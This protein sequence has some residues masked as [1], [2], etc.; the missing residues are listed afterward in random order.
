MTK[1]KLRS[2]SPAQD[3]IHKLRANFTNEETGRSK[4]VKFGAEGYDDY[5]I[6][7]KRDGKKIANERKELYIERHGKDLKTEDP[8]RAGYLSMYIL[9][10]KPTVSAS[11]SDYKKRFNL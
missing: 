7:H 9:W 5:T 8:T 10:N 1:Y 6:L 3:G 4:Q 11:V 2:V